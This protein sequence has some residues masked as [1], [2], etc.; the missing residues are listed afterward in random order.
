MEALSPSPVLHLTGPLL[1]G[2]GQ[3]AGPA[4]A[5]GGRL[6][7]REPTSWTGPVQRLTGWVLPGL[8]DAHCHVG[9]GEHG[10][11]DAATAQEQALT[12]RDAGV[13]L[14]RD[15]GQPG[16]TRWIDD[17]PDLPA[18]VRAGRHIARPRRYLRGFG[19]E[20]EPE[21]LVD[22]VRE[23]ARCGDGWVKLV[24]DW[25]DRSVGDLAPCWPAEVLGPAI[26][27]AHAEGARVTAHCFGED[28]L[29][30]LLAAGLDCLE[31]A[32]GLTD[33][34]IDLAL[35][36]GVTIVPTLVNIENFPDFARAGR[37]R[38]PRYSDHMLRLHRD[39]YATVR[40]AHEAGLPIVTGTDAGGLVPHG[41]LAREVL[42]LVEAGLRPVEAL[43]AACWR[44][45]TWLGRPGLHEGAPAD[46]V[47][48]SADPRIEPRV[49]LSPEAVVLRG[50]PHR[51]AAPAPA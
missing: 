14:I 16:D 11:V 33:D 41:L 7:F 1:T 47:V 15:A 31:H 50:V 29:P 21:Q 39:R 17:R 10:A 19:L 12:E 2:P 38:F 24:G 25:I 4:W 40:R 44:A 46:L 32:T 42:H 3:E 26:A 34:T 5:I 51:G 35:R 27:A 8:V 30:D 18:V 28:C 23:Q 6:T 20:I 45:R 36:Q 37:E 22:A 9:L 43:D 49:L 13:L 48:Y